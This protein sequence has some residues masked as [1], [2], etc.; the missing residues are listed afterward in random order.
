MKDQISQQKLSIVY[1]PDKQNNPIRQNN[2]RQ[3]NPIIS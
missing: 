3:K 2:P 1:T